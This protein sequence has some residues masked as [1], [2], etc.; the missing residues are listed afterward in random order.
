MKIETVLEQCRETNDYDTLVQAVPYAKTIGMSC[1][2]AGEEVI[3]TLPANEN[4]IGNPTLPA[5]HGGVL[6]GFIE[7]SAILHILMLMD[8]PQFPKVVDLSIDYL[9]A[10]LFRDSFAECTVLRMGRRIANVSVVVWQSKKEEPV[11]TARAHL[12]LN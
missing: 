9:S 8:T 6:G 11:A 4:N 3:F 10:G 1:L 12:L 5:I 2:K 7:Q